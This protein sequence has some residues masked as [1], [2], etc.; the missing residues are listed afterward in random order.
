MSYRPMLEAPRDRKI[1]LFGRDDVFGWVAWEGRWEQW[2]KMG[3]V[4]HW[5]SHYVGRD[6]DKVEPEWWV[7]MPPETT[8]EK[9]S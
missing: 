5:T 1:M 7:E 8:P 9:A 4:D 3:G 2:A 6:G